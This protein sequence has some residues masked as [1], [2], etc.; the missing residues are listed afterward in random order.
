[1]I[2][3]ADGT[4][5]KDIRIEQGVITAIAYG[6]QPKGE[7]EV[8]HV[9]GCFVLPGGVDVHTHF[10]MPGANCMT[11]DDFYSGTRA[12]IAGGTTSII[13]FAE[14]DLD[15]PLQQGLDLWHKK[16][17]GKS[18]CD[19]GFHMT[20]SNDRDTTLNEMTSMME[21]GVTSFKVY[22]AY[23]DS[24]GMDLSGI[25]RVLEKV[26]VLGGNLCIHCEDDAIL[27]ALQRKYQE[28]DGADISSHPKS[29]PNE[30]E[31]K[32]IRDVLNIANKVDYPVYIVH[33]STKEG[34]REI[35]K[36]KEI[37]R[38]V[39][40]ETCPH[41]LLL[42]DSKYDLPEF[43]SAKYVMSPPL[44]KREDM[45]EIWKGMKNHIVDTVSTDHC[46]FNFREQK[47]L[48]REDF[49]QIPNGIPSVEHRMIL[50][51][52]FGRWHGL[53]EHKIV[54]LTATNPA[55][56]FGLYPKKGVIQVGSDAD[57]VIMKREAHCITSEKQYQ[58]V[59][60]T[61]YEGVEVQ[62]KISEVYL[63]G[64][65]VVAD[66]LIINEEPTGHYLMRK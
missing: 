2:V 9:E 10:D 30:V 46:S 44:R 14:P 22:T 66:S 49:T 42:D 35:E 53:S 60:Y 3:N 11:S 12:A 24:L 47:E 16:A 48:G 62:Y 15:A 41:Y 33:I 55:K 34:I 13:D 31:R 18:F 56:I 65:R 61:P 28:L 51:Q 32:A 64:K 54:E 40:A 26:K 7:E 1:M 29:R 63:R 37:G 39:Y 17:S 52:H 43:E 59:D 4:Q 19:Y 23:Q 21:Q 27:Q 6:L 36:E 20:V 5:Q 58:Q 45:E 50:M 38:R 57:L 25:Q 8:H